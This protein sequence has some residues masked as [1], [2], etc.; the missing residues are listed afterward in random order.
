MRPGP[1]QDEAVLAPFFAAAR[2]EGDGGPSTA[3]LSA[4]L[5][6]AAEVAAGRQAPGRPSR[7]A[8]PRRGR[9]RPLLG[10]IG[11]WRG[12]AALGVCAALG[13]WIGQASGIAIDGAELT[14][15][16]TSPYSAT[17]QLGAFFDLASVEG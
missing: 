16:S 1:D 11:G 8:A 3:L 13:F 7:M 12:L 4:I 10:P 15:G 9:L 6:D 17:D 5:G 2:N 14:A